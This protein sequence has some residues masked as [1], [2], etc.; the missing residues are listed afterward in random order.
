MKVRW[1]RLLTWMLGTM[2][3]SS[4]CTEM[5]GS[6]YPAPMY[7]S[8][9]SDFSVKIKV[10]DE[11]GTPIKGIEAT[12]KK[13]DPQKHYSDENGEINASYRDIIIP[14]IFLNDIDGEANGGDFQSATL[15]HEDYEL[16]QTKESDKAWYDGAFDANI[17][18]VLKKK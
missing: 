10:T 14:T 3:L 5:Y 2:G 8:P 12:E 7:G 17:T 11:N 1:Y 18:V 15:K 9:Y 13:Y 6:P 16:K 4:G